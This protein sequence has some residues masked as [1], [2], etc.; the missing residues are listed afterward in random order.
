MTR[1][2][3]DATGETFEIRPEVLTSDEIIEMVPKFKGHEKLVKWLMHAFKLDE[4]NYV[5]GYL[6]VKEGPAFVKDLV[7]KDL[8]I[9]VRVDNEQQLDHLPEGAFITVSNHPY[10]ALDG[11]LLIY[12]ITQRRPNFK[13]MVNWFLNKLSAMRPNF[14]AVDAWQ[15]PDPEKRKVSMDGIRRTLKQLKNGEPMGFFPAG[16]MSKVNGKYEQIDREWQP[17]VLQVI[18]KAKV[19]IIPIYFHGGNSFICNMLGII[20]WPARSLMLPRELFKKRKKEIHISVG[21]IITV[22]EQAQHSSS[23]KDFGDFLRDKTYNL[24]REYPK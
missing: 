11:I 22:E 6:S 15:S 19:P 3:T 24:K 1:T 5:H 10:G 8:K 21:D 14:I 9:K 16:A 13:V 12:L 2:Y 20:F 18:Q 17:T 23:L 4:V 7:E